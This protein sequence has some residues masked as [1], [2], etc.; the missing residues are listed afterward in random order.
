MR[1]PDGRRLHAAACGT[2]EDAPHFTTH[3]TTSSCN[4]VQVEADLQTKELRLKF[5]RKDHFLNLMLYLLLY[6]TR[7]STGLRLVN[8]SDLVSYEIIL[9]G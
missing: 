2:Q 6:Y 1:L 7:T 3:A 4:S 9:G 8:G 5:S